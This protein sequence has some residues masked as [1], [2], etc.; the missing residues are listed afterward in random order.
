[1]STKTQ[2]ADKLHSA[3]MKMYDEKYAKCKQLKQELSLAKQELQRIEDKL[4]YYFKLSKGMR[5]IKSVAAESISPDCGA[6]S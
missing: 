5:K 2:R 6:I 3:Y 1:M 4:E